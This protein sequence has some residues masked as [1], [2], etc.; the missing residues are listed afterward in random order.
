MKLRETVSWLMGSLQMNLF[1]RLEQCWESPLTEK[2]RQLVRIL[3]VLEV[4]KYVFREASTQR[5]GRKRL[6]REAIA[7]AFVAKAVY[8]HPYTRRI[9]EALNSAPNLRR[10]CGFVRRS[11][12][13][14][15]ATFSRAFEEFAQSQ[16]GERV[17]DALVKDRVKPLLVGHVS[18]DATAIEGREK[19]IKKPKKEKPAARKRGR[20]RKGEARE[21]KEQKRLDRQCSQTAREA[22]QDLPVHCDVGTK[23]NSKGYQET[24]IGYK[25][26]VDVI[27]CG[28][29]ISAVLTAASLHDSQV[30]IP[31]IKMTSDKV[32][33]L[34]D[35]M[36]SAY[37]AQ[38]IYKVSKSLG[39]VPIIDKNPRGKDLVPMA[40]HE[41]A[42]YN[43]RTASERFARG[44]QGCQFAFAINHGKS[45]C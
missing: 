35:L 16:L 5:L 3:E 1:P 40:P 2:E 37:D 36:D 41:A 26:H 24:W 30:A 14:S 27:D 18:R 33:Y 19:P 25:L 43:E 45:P 42:R 23:K 21:V 29:P 10:I 38:E 39:H 32:T 28:L 6:E 7:R 15:E 8:S 11:D 17:H 44:S 4:Q 13:P 31:M 9:I 12:I 34:Y 22:L 20:P